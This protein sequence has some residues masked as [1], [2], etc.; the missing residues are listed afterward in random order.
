MVNFTNVYLKVKEFCYKNGLYCSRYYNNIPDSFITIR[1]EKSFFNSKNYYICKS[2]P[3]D[4]GK[5][6]KLLINDIKRSFNIKDEVNKTQEK[7]TK[8][9]TKKKNNTGNESEK[10]Y[11]PEIKNV[12][13]NYHIPELL[14]YDLDSLVEIP[15]GKNSSIYVNMRNIIYIEVSEDQNDIQTVQK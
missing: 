4:E 12:I 9:E 11:V 6:T 8:T 1:V 2:T 13:F 5:L 10:C 7:P 15:H 14:N 3:L